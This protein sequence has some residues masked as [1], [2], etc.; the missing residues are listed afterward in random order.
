MIQ[1]QTK[2]RLSAPKKWTKV[3][4]SWMHCKTE[5]CDTVLVMATADPSADP[6]ADQ[7]ADQSADPSADPST[8]QSAASSAPNHLQQAVLDFANKKTNCL[9]IFTTA[10]T[11]TSKS[12]HQHIES[13]ISEAFKSKA[14]QDPKSDLN[15]YL[16]DTGYTIELNDDGNSIHEVHPNGYDF[17]RTKLQSIKQSDTQV[18]HDKVID[19]IARNEVEHHETVRKLRGIEN[20]GMTLPFLPPNGLRPSIS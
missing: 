10:T 8:A 19:R 12:L 11:S 2:S 9:P 18:L 1:E 20:I 3:G 4:D 7:S 5:S 17:R 6:S 13:E 16:K 14:H 15:R